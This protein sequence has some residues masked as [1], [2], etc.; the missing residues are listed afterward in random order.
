MAAS[1]DDILREAL[2]LPERDRADLIG[3]VIESL[4]TGVEEGVEEAWRAELD[5]R[6]QELDSG[7]VQSIPWEVV[8]E[9]LA[10][11]PRG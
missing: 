1:R 10:R 4:D 2:A 11:T 9:R 7:A 5:R 8:R 3:A 6:A